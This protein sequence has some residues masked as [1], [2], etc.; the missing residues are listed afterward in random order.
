MCAHAPEAIHSTMQTAHMPMLAFLAATVPSHMQVPLTHL[1]SSRLTPRHMPSSRS[2]WPLAH[3]ADV[4]RPRCGALQAPRRRWP[5]AQHT[6]LRS[7]MPF[8]WE[9][10]GDPLLYA[11][12]EAAPS[13][14][15]ASLRSARALA[16]RLM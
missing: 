14:E 5:R 12:A 6:S 4:V 13:G 2:H 9:G 1:P 15:L 3:V 8:G 7:N 16:V 10:L 11:R